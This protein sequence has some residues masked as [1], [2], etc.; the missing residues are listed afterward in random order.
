MLAPRVIAFHTE[1]SAD[2]SYTAFV[3]PFTCEIVAIYASVQTVLAGTTTDYFT[4]SVKDGGA[5]GTGTTAIASRGG[6]STNWTALKKYTLLATTATPYQ[7]DK[8]D[9]VNVVYAEGGTVAVGHIMVSFSVVP[10]TAD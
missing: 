9:G 2:G 4:I 5:T 7:I 10:G 3:A 6:K 8:G 1:L